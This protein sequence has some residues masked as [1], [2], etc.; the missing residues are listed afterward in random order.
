M[1][2]GAIIGAAIGFGTVVYI[3][4]QDDG[5]VFNGSVKWYDYVGGTVTGAVLGAGVGGII[6]AEGAVL[7]SALVSTGNKFISDLF[8]Y[9]LTGASFGTWEDYA[10]AFISGR[11][12][13]GLGLG[14]VAKT[15]YDVAG[16]PLINQVVKIGTNRQD[17]FNIEKYAYDVVTRGITTFAPSPW[18]A[19]YRG[20]FKS[21]WDL[22]KRG[23]FA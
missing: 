4:Y 8:A 2:I 18:E 21:I 22:K 14:T 13:K 9:T 20:G 12:I 17:L 3:D 6:S 7:T 10:V 19:F 16:R 15:I 5:Q 1:I 23:Y 11:L